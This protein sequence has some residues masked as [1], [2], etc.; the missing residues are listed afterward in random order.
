MTQV[1]VVN[2]YLSEKYK[3]ELKDETKR[4]KN[5]TQ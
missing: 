3:K 5:G 2:P 1:N 4:R